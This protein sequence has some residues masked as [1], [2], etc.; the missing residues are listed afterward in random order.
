MKVCVSDSYLATADR[1]EACRVDRG[2]LGDLIQENPACIDGRSE[3]DASLGALIRNT[4]GDRV[5]KSQGRCWMYLV[6]N[7]PRWFHRVTNHLIFKYG[8]LY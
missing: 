8:K 6:E 1:V 3:R 7:V 4:L 5:V 2:C